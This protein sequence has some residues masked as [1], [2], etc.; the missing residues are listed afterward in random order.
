MNKIWKYVYV[1]EIDFVDEGEGD[2]MTAK[3]R[4]YF[5][6][7]PITYNMNTGECFIYSDEEIDGLSLFG[8][9][10]PL[11]PNVIEVS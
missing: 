2:E 9:N 7:C 1:D 8:T 3:H 6:S 5:G 10:L 4:D 11:Q